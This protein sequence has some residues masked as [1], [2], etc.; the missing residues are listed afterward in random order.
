MFIADRDNHRIM[1]YNANS[2]I[3]IVVAGSGSAGNNYDQLNTP[4]GVA[5]DQ[6]G[7]LIVGDSSNHRIQNFSNGSYATT[8][9]GA[10]AATPFID[11]L[12]IHVNYYDDVYVTD[13][14]TAQITKSRLNTS[15]EIILK[16]NNGSGFKAD[17][18]LYPYGNVV[19]VN[20]SWYI[21]DS[22]NHRVQK[23][24]PGATN[25]T[26]VAGTTNSF[27][28]NMTQLN[29]PIAIILDNNGY[30]SRK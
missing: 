16:T 20:G 21:A 27:G 18:F 14:G 29:R 11:M 7:F 25:C 6:H 8:I 23:W 22:R 28:S 19:D 30:V 3:G 10:N 24:L 9:A 2:T 4:K 1:K 5:I 12:D 15:T 26:T 17:Q 13:G